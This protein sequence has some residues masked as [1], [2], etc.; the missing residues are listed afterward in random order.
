MKYT[1]TLNNIDALAT[2]VLK[3]FPQQK[4]FALHGSMGAGKTTF[5]NALC[6]HLGVTENTS[7]PTYGIIAEY[8]GMLDGAHISIC[9]MD[10]YRLRDSAEAFDAGVM[11]YLQN[12]MFYCFIEWPS[13]AYS[14]LPSHTM[15]LHLQV[16][17]ET[18]RVLEIKEP[19]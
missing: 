16:Q 12:N 13:I 3:Q 14:L 7:S 8:K 15:H 19:I 10:W 5:I 9:H 1:F 2:T 17:S 18:T 6:K 11:D 4:I